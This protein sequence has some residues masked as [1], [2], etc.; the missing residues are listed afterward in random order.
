MRCPT[1]K[2]RFTPGVNGLR[3][4]PGP[5]CD[6]CLGIIRDEQGFPWLPREVEQLRIDH[7]TGKLVT[8]TREEA[9]PNEARFRQAFPAKKG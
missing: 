1:C 5:G 2:R 8:V 9:F 3:L 4:T 7:N 6:K